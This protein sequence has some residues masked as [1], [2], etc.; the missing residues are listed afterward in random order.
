MARQQNR[1]IIESLEKIDKAL[2]ERI[3]I[4]IQIQPNRPLGMVDEKAKR[5]T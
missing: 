5:D 4:K 3:E 1:R 2:R